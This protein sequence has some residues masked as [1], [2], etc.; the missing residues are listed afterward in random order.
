MCSL[1][2]C[3]IVRHSFNNLGVKEDGWWGEGGWIGLIKTNLPSF[4][5]VFD[6]SLLIIEF[7]IHI[8][9]GVIWGI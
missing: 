7:G 4:V 9:F 6:T 8:Y 3:I 1:K 2:S 5:T